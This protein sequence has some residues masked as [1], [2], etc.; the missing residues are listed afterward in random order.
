[1]KSMKLKYDFNKTYF[2]NKMISIPIID[3]CMYC[4]NGKY[5]RPGD[6]RV[7]D[8]P[9]C[10][11]KGEY[12]SDGGSIEEIPSKCTLYKIV[13]FPEDISYKFIDENKEKAHTT[14][15]SSVVE[16]TANKTKDIMGYTK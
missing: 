6:G 1:M 9:V 14:V 5:M 4:E 15:Y 12:D 3:K 7:V 13:I 16:C 2:F 10:K 11:G 8:C